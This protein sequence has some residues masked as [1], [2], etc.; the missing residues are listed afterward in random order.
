[1]GNIFVNGYRVKNN[2]IKAFKYFKMAAEKGHAQAQHEMGV[3]YYSS[4]GVKR[5][6][7][8]AYAWFYL[9]SQKS[10]HISN[11]NSKSIYKDL[12]VSDKKRANVKVSEFKKLYQKNNN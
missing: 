2:Y 10:I 7:I 1:M 5:D 9:A 8:T 4:Q 12:L 11:K 3:A 6:I